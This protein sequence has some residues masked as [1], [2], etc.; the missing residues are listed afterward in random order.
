MENRE[1]WG[2][3]TV[4]IMK[5]A[6]REGEGMLRKEGRELRKVGRTVERGNG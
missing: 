6:R 2:E 3:G 1:R 4:E 5:A